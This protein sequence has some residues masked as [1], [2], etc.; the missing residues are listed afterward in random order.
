MISKSF[1]TSCSR[2]ASGIARQ[3]LLRVGR[4]R[5]GG[6]QRQPAELRN[7]HHRSAISAP[8]QNCRETEPVG[9]VEDA[10]LRGLRMSASI[11]KRAFAE[12]RKR[13]G[14]IGSHV[15]CALPQGP[16]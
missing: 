1:C 13:D 9:H 15:T 11:S 3:Q 4:A 16:D 2:I 14:K 7:R 6:Q 12:L 5:A 8:G 10:M